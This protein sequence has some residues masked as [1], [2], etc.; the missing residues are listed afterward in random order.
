[1]PSNRYDLKAVLKG[2]AR[3]DAILL[4]KKMGAQQA[5]QTFI[6]LYMSPTELSDLENRLGKIVAANSEETLVSDRTF[7]PYNMDIVRTGLGI[8]A[9][10]FR[11]INERVNQMQ[12]VYRTLAGEIRTKI[13]E[14][15]ISLYLQEEW[16]NDESMFDLSLLYRIYDD[17]PSGFTDSRALAYGILNAACSFDRY[18]IYN[19]S[20][21][22]DL[23][24][25]VPP[26]KDLLSYQTAP[27]GHWVSHTSGWWIFSHTVKNWVWDVPPPEQINDWQQNEINLATAAG[28]TSWYP[29]FWQLFFNSSNPASIDEGEFANIVAQRIKKLRS[30]K[31]AGSVKA[32]KPTASTASFVNSDPES[33]SLGINMKS[34][35]FYGHPY[36]RYS[37]PRSLQGYLENKVPTTPKVIFTPDDHVINRCYMYGNPTFGLGALLNGWS[38]TFS[39]V[40][41]VEQE[42]TV[43]H[44]GTTRRLGRD[45]NYVDSSY[46]T[47]ETIQVP[48][49]TQGET[50]GLYP[51]LYGTLKV[52]SSLQ[53]TVSKRVYGNTGQTRTV[54][55][56]AR[57]GEGG[58]GIPV[59]GWGW[60]ETTETIRPDTVLQIDSIGGMDE[61]NFDAILGGLNISKPVIIVSTD[62]KIVLCAPIQKVKSVTTSYRRYTFLWWSWTSSVQLTKWV[63]QLD[64]TRALAFH[65]DNGATALT[66]ASPAN[67][68]QYFTNHPTA[69][70]GM[71]FNIPVR[72]L[73]DSANIISDGWTDVGIDQATGT[74]IAKALLTSFWTADG[75]RFIRT[76]LH[77]ALDSLINILKPLNSAIGDLSS[78]ISSASSNVISSII[79]QFDE[80]TK[81]KPSMQRARSIFS[82]TNRAVLIQ[83]L[84]SAHAVS[85]ILINAVNLLRST[86]GVYQKAASA[87]LLTAYPSVVGAASNAVILEAARAY[88]DVLYEQ[89]LLLLKKRINRDDGTL[90][91]VAQ[92][93]IA[94]AQMED[95]VTG[96]PDPL[97]ALFDARLNVRHKVTNISLMDR[98]TL[99]TLPTEKI[100]IVYVKVEYDDKG[101]IVRPPA[102]VYK[103][104]SRETL[105]LTSI[106][107]PSWYITF[108]KGI[109]PKIIKNVVTTI[110]G[111]K[112]QKIMTNPNLTQLEKVCYAR[113]LEDWWEIKI[114]ERK[115]P[116]D[117]N[118][119]MD[120]KLVL[121]KSDDFID[122]YVATTGLLATNPVADST[123]RIEIGST[124]MLSP[125]A[126]ASVKRL[127]GV[128]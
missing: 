53:R 64:M 108:K 24:Y 111:M 67:P 58:E 118:Y 98:A 26:T 32:K 106:T 88:L 76:P 2:D 60:E 70:K 113:E 100:R 110:D 36:G 122:G 50:T 6:D 68:M 3:R 80:Q 9:G 37:D 10:G 79:D 47:T 66:A 56:H 128:E 87:T 51:D 63:Y 78:I 30:R 109:A 57:N 49:T 35:I 4:L 77:R 65:I 73:S 115:W 8:R 28:W 34:P 39:I 23:R 114:P 84:T 91:R 85:D 103:L 69:F 19:P 104:Y 16:I 105:E 62:K 97:A 12:A 86:R 14:W 59:K 11:S 72:T 71:Y 119:Q 102:G 81:A 31:R 38:S 15:D 126:Q 112:L 74:A 27:T 41:Y 7:P 29:E 127:N 75:T 55:G 101:E 121:A 89:R 1:M 116:E 33:N 25:W 95:A 48:Q 92:T 61:K 5:A 117:K 123:E 124:W 44:P 43:Y 82:D 83:Q 99:T 17:N 93:E 107:P 22:P 52:P 13:T 20:A 125:D 40:S 96:A 90:M 45:G 120:L 46:T 54:V 21:D 94:L 42:R 18:E